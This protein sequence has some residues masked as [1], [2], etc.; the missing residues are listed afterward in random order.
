MNKNFVIYNST[1][2][3]LRT[4]SC[5]D[6]AFDLQAGADEFI[7][8]G[9]ANCA[10]DAVNPETREII[11]NGGEQV[12]VT[13]QSVVAPTSSIPVSHQLDL[14]WQAMD[15]GTFPKAEPFYSAIKAS[16]EAGA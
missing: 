16:K 13:S 11:P 2:N 15:S 1:G 3:I 7:L 8:E 4:G 6:E 10:K 5:P 9:V 14:L 12:V